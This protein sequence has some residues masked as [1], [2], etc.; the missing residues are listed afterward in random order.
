M[1]KKGIIGLILAGIGVIV[2]IIL[3]FVVRGCII[4]MF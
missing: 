2:L 4:W 1:N 3:F